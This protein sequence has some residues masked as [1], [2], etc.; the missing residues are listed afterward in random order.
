M[1][2][3]RTFWGN[4]WAATAQAAHRLIP[5]RA[6]LWAEEGW[7]FAYP[8]ANFLSNTSLYTLSF[9]D[10]DG[11]VNESELVNYFATNHIEYIWLE[12][13]QLTLPS[14]LEPPHFTV[15]EA[16]AKYCTE[17]GTVNGYFYFNY[18]NGATGPAPARAYHCNFR[19]SNPLPQHNRASR[20]SFGR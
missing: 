9:L 20:L 12:E 4:D 3:M 7:W 15:R 14:L 8:E 11:V 16:V 5:E 10:D 13:A 18:F 1:W 19:S 2:L 17:I 6:S